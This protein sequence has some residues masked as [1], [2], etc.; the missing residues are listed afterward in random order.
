M[1]AMIGLLVHLLVLLI[2]FG[3]IFYLIRLVPIPEP[4]KTAAQVVIGAILLIFLL[5]A[6]VS[7]TAIRYPF[8]GP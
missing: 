5:Y 6:L 7:P 1:A 3:V 4:W 8:Y 2:V